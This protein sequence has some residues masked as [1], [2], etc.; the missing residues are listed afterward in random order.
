MQLNTEAKI[1][2]IHKFSH[3]VNGESEPITISRNKVAIFFFYFLSFVF[4][5]EDAFP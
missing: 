5:R 2:L 3:K 4:N 1:S